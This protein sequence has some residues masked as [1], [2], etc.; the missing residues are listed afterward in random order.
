MQVEKDCLVKDTGNK[1]GL[2][3]QAK[4]YDVVR[5]QL[6]EKVDVRCEVFIEVAVVLRN[7]GELRLR[8]KE[9]RKK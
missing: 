4:V 7:L 9:A 3:D 6:R 1:D 5:C 2:A 8:A